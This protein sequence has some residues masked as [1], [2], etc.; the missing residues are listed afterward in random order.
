MSTVSWRSIG[1]S[2]IGTSHEASGSECQDSH[3]CNEVHTDQGPVLLAL[4]SDGAG[5]A[6]KSAI[7]SRLICD[8]LF[9]KVLSFFQEAGK[10]NDLNSRLIASWIQ[11]F[12]DEVILQA[13]A[14][15]LT[16]REYACTLVGA[17][18]GEQV[19]VFFQVGDGAIVYSTVPGAPPSL[20]FWPDRGEYENTTFFVTQASFM[21]QLQFSLVQERVAEIALLSDGLQRLALDYK[22]RTPYHP[23]FSGLFGPLRRTSRERLPALNAHL[24]DYLNSTRVNDRTDDD[25]TVVLATSHG[26]EELPQ[27]N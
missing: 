13:A 4:V 2:V 11:F 15:G 26:E 21:D 23:F 5:S 12:R 6:T 10:I 14:D 19:A 25:K 7:G 3:L 24:A 20:A 18:V 16:E 17:I 27:G 22:S 8:V 1:A 9:D